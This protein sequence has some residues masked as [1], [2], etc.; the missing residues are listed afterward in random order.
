MSVNKKRALWL[1]KKHHL[2]VSAETKLK[3]KRVSDR[4]KPRAEKP[5]E[6]YGI[7]MTKIKLEHEG[8]AY[9]VLVIDWYTKKIVGH[10]IDD[11]SKSSHWLSALNQAACLQYPVSALVVRL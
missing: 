5:N 7:D 1:M 8:W 2:I 11:R 10:T 4:P 3:A 6:I 9:L